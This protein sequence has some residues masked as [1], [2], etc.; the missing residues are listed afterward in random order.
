MGHAA[1]RRCG[2]GACVLPAV[3]SGLHRSTSRESVHLLDGCRRGMRSVRICLAKRDRAVQPRLGVASARQDVPPVRG[4][5]A[6]RATVGDSDDHGRRR[7]RDLQR[8]ERVSSRRLRNDQIEGDGRVQLRLARESS[9]ADAAQLS[10]G[11][12]EPAGRSSGGRQVCAYLRSRR[13]SD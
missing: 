2:A 6:S 10:I 13:L 7:H 12:R 8:H 11:A 5:R 3:A 9:L 4:I 1:R